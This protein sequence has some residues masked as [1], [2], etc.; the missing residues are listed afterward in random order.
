MGDIGFARRRRIFGDLRR[1]M[2]VVQAV[3]KS[4]SSESTRSMPGHAPLI[5]G[6]SIKACGATEV[7]ESAQVDV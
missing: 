2:H 3:N 7:V 6:V 4:L 5:D 1:R